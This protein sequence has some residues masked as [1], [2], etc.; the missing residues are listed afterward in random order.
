M[1]DMND[2]ITTPLG[3]KINQKKSHFVFSKENSEGCHIG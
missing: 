1:I 3:L 2:K